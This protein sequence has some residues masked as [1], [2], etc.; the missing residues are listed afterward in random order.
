MLSDAQKMEVR[1]R[2]PPRFQFPP[3]SLSLVR[4]ALGASVSW[5]LEL[6]LPVSSQLFGSQKEK[7]ASHKPCSLEEKE[8]NVNEEIQTE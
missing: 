7:K 8:G 3:H 1:Q 5:A 2:L 4:R 6:P